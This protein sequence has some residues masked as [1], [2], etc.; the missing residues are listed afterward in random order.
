MPSTAIIE[1]T[2]SGIFRGERVSNLC[3]MLLDLKQWQLSYK[4]T[5]N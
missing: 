4:K 5:K 1:L 3:S 2:N